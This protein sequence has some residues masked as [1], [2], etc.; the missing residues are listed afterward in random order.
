MRITLRSIAQVAG[1]AISVVA[2]AI[3]VA[4]ADPGATGAVLARAVPA[5]IVLAV[6][7]LIAQLGVLAYRWR[8]LLPADIEGRSVPYRVVTEALLVGNLA[9]ALLPGRLGEVVRAVAVARRGA[10]DTASSIGTVVLERVLDV[11]V[12]AD[13]AFI[14]AVVAG[15]P[16][17]LSDAL[18]IIALGGTVVIVLIVSGIAARV[19]D[20]L[21]AWAPPRLQGERRASVLQWL[22]RLV[23]GAHAGQR[24]GIVVVG[25]MATV[26]SVLMDG[27]IFWAVGLSL[28]LPLEWSHALLL[29]SAGILV[30]GIP[31]A[32]ANVGTFELAVAWVGMT[33][34]IPTES[35]LALALV[36]HLVIVVPLSFGGALVLLG[37][38][39]SANRPADIERRS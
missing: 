26:A 2:I 18:A 35:G 8:L 19:M 1:L 9:N 36:A 23:D 11:V 32:P 31:S 38:V 20:R 10:V 7:V 15:A 3:V 25:L 39:R 12:L 33:L 6:A 28:D 5:P 21:A 30:T 22:A 16:S 14:G 37:S 17:L 27:V 24:S 29:A 34:G 4:Q 13:A